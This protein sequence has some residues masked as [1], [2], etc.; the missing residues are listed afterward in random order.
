MTRATLLIA[1]G[2]LL[3]CSAMA[4]NAG[5]AP[6]RYQ[7]APDG[8]GF[9]R[10]DTETGALAHCDRSDGVWR[11]AVVTEDSSDVNRRILALEEELAALRGDLAELAEHL[12]AIE[13]GEVETPETSEDLAE[14]QEKEFDEALSFAERMMRRFFDMVRELK[15]EE[16]PQQI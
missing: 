8:D 2:L 3:S 6:G 10:L 5:S 13:E 9:I 4:E 1:G 14:R 15:N 16:P 7:I 12:A 11:C